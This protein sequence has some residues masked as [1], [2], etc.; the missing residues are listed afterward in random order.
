MAKKES[1]LINMF[2][3]L[4]VVA[5][6]AST[7]LGFVYELTKAPIAAAK[8]AKKIRAIDQVV[9]EYE[10]NPVEDMYRLPAAAGDDSLEVY[11]AMQGGK[12]QQYAIRTYST[13]GYGGAVWL[14]VG[15]DPD[16]TIHDI[17]V[18]EHKETPGLGTKMSDPEFVDQYVGQD[19][20]TFDINVKKDGGSVDALTG[21]TITSRAFSDATQR[22]Y[23]TIKN[24]LRND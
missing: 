24:Q 23:L 6:V 2:V 22:A 20:G 18:L 11:P 21:A 7:A 1:T 16:G 3:S 10:N 19:P 15:I 8:L 4:A 14:M 12:V 9:D 13:K 17:A 5:L